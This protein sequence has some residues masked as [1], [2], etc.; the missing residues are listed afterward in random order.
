VRKYLLDFFLLAIGLLVIALLIYLIALSQ[1][2]VCFLGI[3]ALA[4]VWISWYRHLLN[5]AFRSLGVDPDDEDDLPY[6]PG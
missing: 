6:F 3:L 5:L 1:G 4:V 2:W